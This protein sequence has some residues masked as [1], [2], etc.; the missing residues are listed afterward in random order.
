LKFIEKNFVEQLVMPP[1]VKC[2]LQASEKVVA[3]REV[4]GS[5][6]FRDIL[7]FDGKQQVILIGLMPG[8]SLSLPTQGELRGIINENALNS[9]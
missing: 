2:P 7:S 6:V 4:V 8:H 9:L 5:V 1:K 3:L